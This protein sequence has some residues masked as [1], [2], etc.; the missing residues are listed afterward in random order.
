MVEVYL[1]LHQKDHKVQLFSYMWPCIFSC[2]YCIHDDAN[3]YEQTLHETVTFTILTMS[4]T[5]VR[6]T[7]FHDWH[8]LQIDNTPIWYTLV[9]LKKI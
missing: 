1:I 7:V 4:Y 2:L 9:V 6:T 5:K 8:C 3:D